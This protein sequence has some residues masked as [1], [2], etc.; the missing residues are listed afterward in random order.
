MAAQYT[1]IIKNS[2]EFLRYLKTKAQL[3]HLSNVFFRDIQYGIQSYAEASGRKLN[4]GVAESM[5]AQLVSDFEKSGVLKPV[6]PGS[7]TLNFPEFR[8]PSQKPVAAAKPAPAATAG[9]AAQPAA[10]PTNP[11]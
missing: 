3:F 7:W 11:A 2:E 9:A 10:A 5:A 8:K 4:Y 6:K 1:D